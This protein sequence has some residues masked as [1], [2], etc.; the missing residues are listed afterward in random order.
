MSFF[1]SSSSKV[2]PLNQA[3]WLMEELQITT[4][5]FFKKSAIMRSV[6]IM[7]T[8]HLAMYVPTQLFPV[9]KVYVSIQG[10]PA[11][12]KTIF[13]ERYSVYNKLGFILE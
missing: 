5:N 13:R 11:N 7:Q 9:K 10:I 4:D 8:S 12:F 3:L 1:N 2:F 6:G